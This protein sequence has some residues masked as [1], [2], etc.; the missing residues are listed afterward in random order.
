MVNM[1]MQ[2]RHAYT[3]IL[4]FENLVLQNLQKEWRKILQNLATL[5]KKIVGQI[6]YSSF[7]LVK[8]HLFI[9]LQQKIAKINPILLFIGKFC[10]AKFNFVTAHYEILMTTS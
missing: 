6:W 10:L 1:M 2:Y 3:V 5:G 7:G 9:I 8:K 4:K